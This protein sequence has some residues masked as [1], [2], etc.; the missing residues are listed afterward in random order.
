MPYQYSDRLDQLTKTRP[1]RS[2][3][4]FDEES[5]VGRLQRRDTTAFAELLEQYGAAMYRVAHTF[6]RDEADAEEV[7]RGALL[8]VRDKIGLFDGRQS[9][10]TWLRRV[11]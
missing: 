10:I 6:T 9:L 11:A 2:V 8:A 7:M 1:E 5:L 3:V 4:P